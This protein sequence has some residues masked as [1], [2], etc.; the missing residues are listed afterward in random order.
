M[1]NIKYDIFISYKHEP[2]GDIES[3]A[4][5]LYDKL[6]E[7][8]YIVYFNP[9]N[10]KSGDFEERIISN[11]KN[12]TVV[13]LVLTPY[14]LKYLQKNLEEDYV[15][16]ELV[17]AHK[18]NVKVVPL[19][20]AGAKMPDG[21]DTFPKEISFLK[22][23][24]PLYIPIPNEFDI[25]NFNKLCNHFLE[26][27]IA[28]YTYKDSY[29]LNIH[30]DVL[31][32]F[33]RLKEDSEHGSLKAKFELANMYYY[34][35]AD[36]KGGSERNFIKAFELYMELINENCDYKFVAANMVGRMYNDGVVGEQSFKKGFEYHSISAENGGESAQTIA[37]MKSIGRGC[38]Y[39][40]S[41]AENLYR[42]YVLNGN[43]IA[44]MDFAMFYLKNNKP[45]DALNTLKSIEIQSPQSNYEIGKIYK[46]GLLHSPPMPDYDKAYRYFNFAV[47]GKHPLP[48]AYAE[49][50]DLCF[51]G[52]SDFEVDMRQAESH[53]LKGAEL[54]NTHCMYMLGFMYQFGY[55]HHDLKKAEE[56]FLLADVNGDVNSAHH[57]AMLYQQPQLKNYQQAVCYAKK[58]AYNG[59]PEGEYI[60]AN[61]LFLGRGCLPDELEALKF[62][63]KALKHGIVQAELMIEKIYELFKDESLDT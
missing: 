28:K 43:D 14:C 33:K 24:T 38:E 41:E 12:S 58:S 11:V 21:K 54:G 57:L 55:V 9:F 31:S 46:S 13:L 56:Y 26:K 15:R 40:F 6:S 50:G 59:K 3:F 30:F 45:K 39:S 10:E 32:E 48:E 61:L 18:N 5:N 53:Y 60:Y 25:S 2:D 34:G 51:N 47:S 8:G 4:G 20:L 16:A 7:M 35:I 1:S 37:Y 19:M 17:A 42:A 27:P 29:N 44:K 63:K 22:K 62:Y 36:D 23:C 49:M 52:P